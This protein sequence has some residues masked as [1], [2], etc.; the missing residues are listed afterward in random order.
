MV[1]MDRDQQEAQVRCVLEM[2]EGLA[3]LLVDG[4][5]GD[6]RLQRWAG[7][8][9]MVAREFKA[10]PLC[11]QQAQWTGITHSMQEVQG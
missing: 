5:Q 6:S 10:V 2:M 9:E 3:A 7:K 4:V 11:G 1:K 8:V